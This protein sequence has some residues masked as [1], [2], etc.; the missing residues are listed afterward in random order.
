MTVVRTTQQP[1]PVSWLDL[2]LT[3]SAAGGS[4]L[5]IV[6]VLHTTN[7]RVEELHYRT[8]DGRCS[9]A[10]L[11]DSPRA[12]VVAARLRR[13]VD[14]V[15]VTVR[16]ETGPLP[17]SGRHAAGRSHDISGLPGPPR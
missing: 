6:S 17:P 3:A 15:D 12:A 2:T 13:C 8:V 11:V 16:P 10:V 9:A 4:L 14:V 7:V 1:A 5:K